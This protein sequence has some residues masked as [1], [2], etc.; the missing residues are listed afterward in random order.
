M[1]LS[2]SRQ[3]ILFLSISASPGPTFDLVLKEIGADMFRIT[4]FLQI[5]HMT[6]QRDAA[7]GSPHTSIASFFFLLGDLQEGWFVN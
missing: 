5:K 7:A 6:V 3:K 1:D 2:A 4:R